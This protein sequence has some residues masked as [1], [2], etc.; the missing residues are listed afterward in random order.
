MA[1]SD[2][3]A[4]YNAKDNLE[5]HIVRNFLEQNGVEAFATVD[6]SVAG[7]W[8][9]GLLPEIHKP[10]VWVDRSAI[11]QARPLLEQFERN[12]HQHRELSARSSESDVAP[13]EAVC[14]ECDR[15]ST[16]PRAKNGTVQDCPHCGAF[17]DV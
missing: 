12:K 14:E 17:M 8:M 6:D 16:F 4:A 11:E 2:P 5:A 13:I 7:V 3:V 10:Q 15:N 1:I 9:F